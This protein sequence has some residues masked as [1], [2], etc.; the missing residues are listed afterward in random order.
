MACIII[1]GVFDRGWVEPVC[2]PAFHILVSALKGDAAGVSA[3]GYGSDCEEWHGW[4]R[5]AEIPGCAERSA[6]AEQGCSTV[7]ILHTETVLSSET[8]F[9]MRNVTLPSCPRV[10]AIPGGFGV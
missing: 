5:V 6:R 10:S 8:G 2:P 4:C 9:A 7:E 1:S 3:W